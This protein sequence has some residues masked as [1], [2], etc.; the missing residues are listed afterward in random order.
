MDSLETA[1][2]RSPLEPILANV[3]EARE[4]LMEALKAADLLGE[5]II[6]IHLGLSVTNVDD[7]RAIL[8]ERTGL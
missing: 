3:E 8:S 5:G 1:T 4:L 2:T 7:A 6:H